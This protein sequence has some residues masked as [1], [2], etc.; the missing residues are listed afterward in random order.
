MKKSYHSR[1][2]PTAEASMTRASEEASGFPAGP[3]F[4]TAAIA[5]SFGSTSRPPVGDSTA[6]GE[7]QLDQHDIQAWTAAA[8]RS[9]FQVHGSSCASLVALVRPEA[10]RSSTS[11]SQAKGSTPFSLAV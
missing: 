8:S 1:A 11:V 5:P 7:R 10:I 2:E 4:S 3:G 9:A 6:L